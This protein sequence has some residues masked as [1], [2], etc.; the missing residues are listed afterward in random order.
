V[1]TS[2]ILLLITILL[3]TLPFFITTPR[4]QT[5]SSAGLVGYWP[6][7]EGPGSAI[8]YDAGPHGHD[9]A[10]MGATWGSG[11]D[12]YALNFDGQDDFI[13]FVSPEF[14]LQSTVTISAWI[15]PAAI[16]KYPRIAG[17]TH[18]SDV[19]PWVIWG[20]SIN[21]NHKVLLEL[22]SPSGKR[23]YARSSSTI[24]LNTW[25]HVAGTYDSASI[26]IYVNGKLEDTQ[27]FS[28][29]LAINTE[30]FSIA[31]SSYGENY[32][33][34]LIDD[35]YVYNRTLSSTEIYELYTRYND[36]PVADAGDAYTGPEGTAILFDGSGSI[37]PDS[38]GDIVNY[39]WEFGDGSTGEGRQP[40]HT[41]SS[42]GSFVVSLEVTDNMGATNRDVTV[43]TI[44]DTAPLADFSGTPEAGSS[45]LTVTFTDTSASHD[46]IAER[47]WEFGDGENS[48]ATNPT[49]IYTH[50]GAFTVSLRAKEADGDQDIETKTNYIIVT[51]NEPPVAD[52]EGPYTGITDEVIAFNGS[53]SF[54]PDG[55]ITAWSWE[56]GDGNTSIEE[57]PTHRYSSEGRYT[58]T[59]TVT[60]NRGAIG[61]GTT[62]IDIDSR[63]RLIC[64]LITPE[65]EKEVMS[66]SINF[67]ALVTS[68][69]NPVANATVTFYI[70]GSEVE[71]VQSDLN[72][73]ANCQHTLP[74]GSHQWSVQAIKLGYTTGNSMSRQVTNNPPPI[75][76]PWANYLVIMVLVIAGWIALAYSIYLRQHRGRTSR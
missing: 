72:G 5:L 71:S 55:V 63:P 4:G 46:G 53:S 50:E 12:G 52:A 34:G 20:L 42:D 61:T 68:Q 65:N 57:S 70:N 7:N 24:P 6:F 8:V 33:D 17:K 64:T 40:S 62:W 74:T 59:L 15:N 23:G 44:V 31:R 38:F 48:T 16:V 54:D 75:S 41:Y 45:P 26:K 47:Y 76:I 22:A 19:N 3:F 69:G 58:I 32:F 37:D 49:H 21:N 11:V 14:N 13:E 9:A 36:N 29:P 43:V 35:V 67:Q 73:Y 51:T 10:I 30:P 2:W 1:R 39:H 66:V 25:T 18:T 60:D 28:E 56:F 27:S